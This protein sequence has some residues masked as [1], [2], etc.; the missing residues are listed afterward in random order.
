MLPFLVSSLPALAWTLL[1][2]LCEPEDYGLAS[3]TPPKLEC[4]D[5][6]HL[7][8]FA[9]AGLWSPSATSPD[10]CSLQRVPST[11][12]LVHSPL[13][14]CARARP[15]LAL[16]TSSPPAASHHP[17]VE[18]ARRGGTRGGGNT[19]RACTWPLTVD[20]S[21]ADRTSTS[22]AASLEPALTPAREPCERRAPQR[23]DALTRGEPRTFAGR[24]LSG[25]SLRTVS[26]L[27][28]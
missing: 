21:T 1:L 28:R 22:S 3:D 5:D 15:P 10:S 2:H 19:T 11:C 8:S 25:L 23:A 24:T 13:S 20:T 4:R 17:E 18:T 14:R 27:A 26:S 12:E 16:A 7:P 6:F 9:A